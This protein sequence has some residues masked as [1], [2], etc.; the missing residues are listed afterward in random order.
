MTGFSPS[1][2]D[3]ASYI[4][5]IYKKK[6]PMTAF[7]LQKLVYYSQAWSVA[8]YEQRIFRNPIF[9]WY[10][11]PT[12]KHLYKHHKG[13]F[14]V[15]EITCG[16]LLN[17]SRRDKSVINRVVAFYGGKTAQWLCDLTSMEKPFTEAREGLD[18]C[19]RGDSEISLSSMHEYYSSL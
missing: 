11:G 12:E 1:S 16:D 10:S 5:K 3:V 19:E 8:W 14:Y 17:I 18:T 15:Y 6:Y 13:L 4:L 7:K 9:A 2:F